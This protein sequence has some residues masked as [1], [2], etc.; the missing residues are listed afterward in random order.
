MKNPENNQT[1][2]G[3]GAKYIVGFY[4][5]G[6]ILTYLSAIAGIVGIIL[7]M[8]VNP[9]WGVVCLFVSGLCDAFD[10]AVASTRKNRT[11]ADRLFGTQIDSLSDLI[12]FGV[13]PIFIGVGLGMREWY[14]FVPLC[15][16]PLCALIRLAYY[17]VTEETRKQGKRVAFEGLP[18]TNAAI[19]IP[20]FYLVA[21]M[22]TF[23][24]PLT[25]K[26]VML[27]GYCL[28]AFL[29]V[30]RF[31]MPKAGI[32]GLLI[33]IGIVTALVISL[34]LVRTYVCDVPL[35]SPVLS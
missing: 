3:E 20:V 32:R 13:A 27:F 4:H 31:H 17:N 15:L 30:W 7:S 2:K 33:T 24:S 11:D 12:A 25:V 9:F 22:F 19:G 8:T 16:F 21:T 6:V 26:L 14:F 35:I 18:V 1:V 28:A 5:Y 10:G 29:F 34:A 23:I